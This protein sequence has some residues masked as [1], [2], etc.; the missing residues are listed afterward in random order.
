MSAARLPIVLGLAV[1]AL[2][3]VRAVQFYVRYETA[4]Y[5]ARATWGRRSR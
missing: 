2:A 4:T 3:A 5:R 1:E